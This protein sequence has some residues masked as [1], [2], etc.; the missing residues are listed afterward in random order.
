MRRILKSSFFSRLLFVRVNRPLSY[1]GYRI[2]EKFTAD[3]PM[4]LQIRDLLRYDLF[5]ECV[6]RVSSILIDNNYLLTPKS[7]REAVLQSGNHDV[8]YWPF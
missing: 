6:R 1:C 8:C 4:A 7:L 2:V 5:G 3:Y